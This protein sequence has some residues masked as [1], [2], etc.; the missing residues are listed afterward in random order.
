MGW[1]KSIAAGL[2]SSTVVIAA[3]FFISRESFKNI[4][5]RSLESHK[6]ELG[7]EATRR[8]LA[9]QSQIQFKERQLSE[10]YGPIYAL[11][12]RIRPIDDLWN[13]GKL[14]TIDEAAKKVMRD[15]NDR[16]VEIILTKSHL[17]QGDQIPKSYTQFLTHVPVW[18][19]FLDHPSK[20]WSAYQKLPEA[21]YDTAFEQEVYATTEQ[22]K[23]DLYQLYQEYGLKPV[24][25]TTAR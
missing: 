17:I 15:S 18:H 3:I 21:F 6:H 16:I 1:L 13:K 5:D 20:N 24:K 11:L 14:E 8:E 12:K 25:T 2:V 10:F 7:V 4:L 9:L 22:L 19:A 23:R